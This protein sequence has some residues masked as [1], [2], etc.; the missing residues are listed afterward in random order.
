MSARWKS[1]ALPWKGTATWVELRWLAS[2]SASYPGNCTHGVTR[3]YQ[4]APT[5]QA[6]R[7]A[8]DEDHSRETDR[9]AITALAGATYWTPA[10]PGYHGGSTVMG[11]SKTFIRSAGT[12]LLFTMT[13]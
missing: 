3:R 2:W 5:R 1:E 12:C 9:E 6:E 11:S 8:C 4:S 7:Q 13:M 10:A